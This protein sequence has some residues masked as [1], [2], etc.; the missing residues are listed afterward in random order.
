MEPT[1]FQAQWQLG[2]LAPHEVP[3]A[4][5]ELLVAG[6]DTPALRVISA[7]D[8]PS[9]W[10]IRPWVERYLTEAQL[11][12]ITDDAARWRLAYQAAEE[13]VAGTVTPLEGATRLWRL[14]NA[15]D[16]PKSL[17]YFVYLA[18]D[19]GEGPRKPAAE[20]AWFDERIIETAR[21]LL[22]SRSTE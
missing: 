10:E 16:M 5:V 6:H 18:A 13:I 17:R 7:F 9:H 11:P 3:G 15:L 22:A 4:A 2:E 19:Y 20:A 8:A 21:E 1:L 14:C 12:P